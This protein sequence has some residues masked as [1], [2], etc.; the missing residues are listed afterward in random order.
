[1]S[2]PIADHVQDALQKDLMNIPDIA[3]QGSVDRS[4]DRLTDRAREKAVIISPAPARGVEDRATI[5]SSSRDTL[6]AV[7]GL[8]ERARAHGEDRSGKVAAAAA[9]VE[10]G[11]LISDAVLQSTAERLLDSGFLAG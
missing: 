2:L 11:A 3:N 4:G 5:S 9:M 1:M 10:S 7:E 8:A 6:A